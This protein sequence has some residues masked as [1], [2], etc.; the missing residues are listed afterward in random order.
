MAKTDTEGS[1]I[2]QN[3]DKSWA[4]AGGWGLV[5]VSREDGQAVWGGARVN[6]GTVPNGVVKISC[7]TDPCLLS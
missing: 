2:Q 5:Y 7:F 3:S 6:A 1:K 4:D